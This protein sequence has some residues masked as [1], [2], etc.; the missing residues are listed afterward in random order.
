MTK[1]LILFGM[2]LTLVAFAETHGVETL[3]R[4]IHS[5][6]LPHDRLFLA[7]QAFVGRDPEPEEFSALNEGLPVQLAI[8]RV[9]QSKAAAYFSTRI[10]AG[11]VCPL[12]ARQMRVM[13]GLLH[14]LGPQLSENYV[15]AAYCYQ[16]NVV[17]RGRGV[18]A[19]A[20]L[21]NLNAGCGNGSVAYRKPSGGSVADLRSCQQLNW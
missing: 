1:F 9:V 20:A 5:T 3:P 8:Q 6:L 16:S 11:Q 2:S 4:N 12:R 13:H 7:Y 17:V 10:P 14:D 21:R 15:C 18:T 19:D